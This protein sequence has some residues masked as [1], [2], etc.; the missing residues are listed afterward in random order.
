MLFQT[1]GIDLEDN[2]VIT[3]TTTIWMLT[4]A[5]TNTKCCMKLRNLAQNC[6]LRTWPLV[7]RLCYEHNHT[8]VNETILKCVRD[9]SMLK[10]F[11][12]SKETGHH[13][14]VN[15]LNLKECTKAIL[16]SWFMIEK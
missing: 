2:N 13:H 12:M 1:S 5:K 3:Q 4:T 15:N 9:K 7:M 14:F 11:D 8:G 10:H 6:Q 16:R